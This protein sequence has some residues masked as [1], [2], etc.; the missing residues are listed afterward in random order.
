M[1]YKMG[2]KIN[3]TIFFP[4]SPPPPLR[5]SSRRDLPIKYLRNFEHVCNLYEPQVRTSYFYLVFLAIVTYDFT[6]ISTTLPNLNGSI[7]RRHL[8]R[9]AELV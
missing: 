5:F 8:F 3:A 6:I 7:Y 4:I 2:K 1:G 9:K